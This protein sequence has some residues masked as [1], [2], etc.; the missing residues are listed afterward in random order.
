MRH[1]RFLVIVVLLFLG[2]ATTAQTTA[3]RT[4][5][6]SKAET[7]VLETEKTRFAAMVA[8]NKTVLDQVLANELSYTHATGKNESKTE[9]VTAITSQ[10]VTYEAIEPEEINPRIYSETAVVT[11]R[12]RFKVR[13][14]SGRLSFRARFT[15]VYVKRAGRWQLVAWQS[16]RLPDQ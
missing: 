16:T 5:T 14:G 6:L 7:A 15:D 10:A 4:R 2:P 12:A 9:F 3:T 8:G 11:G 1:S 13:S